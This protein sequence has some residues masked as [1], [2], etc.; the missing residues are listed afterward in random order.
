MLDNYQDL[1]DELLGTPKLVRDAIAAGNADAL[2]LINA[3]RTRDRLALER[4]QRIKNQID[5]H[6][7][8]LS[9]DIAE[10]AGAEPEG[11]TVALLASFE[12]SRGDLVSLL[13]NLT[14]RDWERT[15]TVESGGI[16]T[17]ADEVETHVEFD[18]TMRARLESLG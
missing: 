11:D 10:L 14:L 7:K 2:P 3:M 16:V 8:T 13:M 5:P 4:M 12:T 17:L 9:D 15:A 1:I 6:L 18:E